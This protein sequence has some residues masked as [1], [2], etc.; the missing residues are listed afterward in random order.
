MM[1]TNLRGKRLVSIGLFVAGTALLGCLVGGVAVWAAETG[2]NGGADTANAGT[3]TAQSQAQLRAK[4]KEAGAFPEQKYSIAS[5]LDLRTAMNAARPIADKTDATAGELLTALTSVQTKIDA[6]AE[7]QVLPDLGPRI[8]LSASLFATNRQGPLNNVALMWATADASEAFDIYRA[9]GKSENF[10][11]IYSGQGASFNDTSLEAGTYSY[12]LVAHQGT[13]TLTS[14]VEVI[15][16]MALPGTV[17]EYSNQTGIGGNLWEPLKVGDTYYRFDGQRDGT[18]MNFVAKTSADGKNWKDGPVVLDKT[19]APDLD[20]FKL[21]ASNIFYD[22]SH[23]QIVWWAH[24]ERS[25]GYGD[26]RALVATAKPGERFTVHHIYN[27]RGIQV[28]DMSVFTD[29]DGQGYM[30]AA[31]NVAGQGANATLTI[32]KLN[33]DYTDVTGITN[34]VMEDQYREAPHIIKTGGFYYLFFSQA[35]GWYPSRAAYMSARSLDGR[36][37][38]ARDITNNSTF[39]AQ[40]GGI[41]D[42]G[43]GDGFVPVLMANRWVRGDGTSGNSVVPLHCAQGFAFGDYAPTLLLEPT[44]HLIV[45]LS[46]GQLLSQ[47]QPASASIAGNKDHEVGKAFDG[48]YATSFQS[49]DKKWPFSVTTDLG[50]PC[51]VRNVQISW[52]IFK[53]SEAYYK[54]TIEGSL[55]GQDW[56]VLLDRTDDKDTTV[57][58]TYG[59]SSDM[60][61]DS[62]T[63]RYVRINVQK[64]VLHNNPN[65]WYPPTLYEVKVY[66]EKVR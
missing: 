8:A 41:L 45:P 6:L 50:A 10:S 30:V 40:S 11:K 25:K 4:L 34:K 32:F 60:L 44:K 9:P 59:F 24:W 5:W 52:H 64:A 61:S 20:D 21:E 16:T 3:D 65:N 49:D 63:A 12:K 55:D 36:W 31:S 18:T 29:D 15:T 14:N 66:G 26:G 39:S 54:Y 35:A 37:S 17:Q 13:Q 2:A 43:N 19:S 33:A 47:D 38:D 7:R 1:K 23:D 48:N 42:Y 58:K 22:K 28:R 27:P 57:S 46:S 56:H 62:P 53:G 51:Q